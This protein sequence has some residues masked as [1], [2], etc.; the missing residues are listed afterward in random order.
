MTSIED[1]IAKALAAT[2]LHP[3]FPDQIII[4]STLEC[5][6]EGLILPTPYNIQTIDNIIRLYP[7]EALLSDIEMIRTRAIAFHQGKK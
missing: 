3:S 5:L 6:R 1:E 2:F 4:E 7:F